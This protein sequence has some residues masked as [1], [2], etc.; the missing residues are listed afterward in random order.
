M[1]LQVQVGSE[2]S[3]R[4]ADFKWE[5]ASVFRDCASESALRIFET[6]IRRDGLDFRPG[7]EANVACSIV[8]LGAKHWT[9]I[10]LHVLP[11]IA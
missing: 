5:K 3:R 9:L 4:L 10:F 11:G 6:Y 8:D 1:H 2:V 7:L